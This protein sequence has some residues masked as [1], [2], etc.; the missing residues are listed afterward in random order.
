MYISNFGYQNVQT[1]CI[2]LQ[3]IFPETLRDLHR[4][5]GNFSFFLPASNRARA[6]GVA[7]GFA[8]SEFKCF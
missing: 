6:Q 3:R 7:I 2:I 8:P 5:L 1:F 4:T